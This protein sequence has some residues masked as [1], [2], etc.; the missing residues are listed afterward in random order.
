[1][2]S[3]SSLLVLIP[4]LLATL[5]VAPDAAAEHRFGADVAGDWSA[6]VRNGIQVWGGAAGLTYG[7]QG[8]HHGLQVALGD[9]FGRANDTWKHLPGLTLSWCVLYGDDDDRRPYSTLGVQAAYTDLLPVMPVVNASGGLEWTSPSRFLR[10]G[11]RA[12]F[13]PAPA[14]GGGP[15]LT[16]GVRF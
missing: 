13:V 11:L 10:A 15:E 14:I 1:M 16:A 12:F 9:R 7:L 2:R 5:T 4:A 8:A 3:L 6:N